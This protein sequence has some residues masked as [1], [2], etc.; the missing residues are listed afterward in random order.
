MRGPDDGSELGAAQ[1]TVG[2]LLLATAVGELREA[3]RHTAQA[4]A[5]RQ[6]AERL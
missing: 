5:A 3:Q 1:L 6:G 4:P 2:L